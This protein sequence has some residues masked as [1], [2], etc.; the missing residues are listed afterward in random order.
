MAEKRDHG[1]SDLRRAVTAIL[2]RSNPKNADLRAALAAYAHQL[3]LTIDN[4]QPR[5][6]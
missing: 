3:C 4:S 2:H 6:Q 5:D 1:R